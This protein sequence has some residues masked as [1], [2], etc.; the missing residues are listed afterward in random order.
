MSISHSTH[1][2]S[3]WPILS[4]LGLDLNKHDLFFLIAHFLDD[5]NCLFWLIRNS[6]WE[7]LGY[8]IQNVAGTKHFEQNL[9][10]DRLLCSYIVERPSIFIVKLYTQNMRS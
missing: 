6:K 9:C 8:E 4:E 5:S 1:Q 10:M 7:G 3:R 2:V